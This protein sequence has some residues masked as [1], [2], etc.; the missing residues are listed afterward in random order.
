MTSGPHQVHIQ[1]TNSAEPDRSVSSRRTSGRDKTAGQPRGGTQRD[2][3]EGPLNPQVLGSSPRGVRTKAL[4]RTLTRAF[5]VLR[6]GVRN[7]I[8]HLRCLTP[9]VTPRLHLDTWG[10]ALSESLRNRF[11]AKVDRSGEHNAWTGSR[12][13][14]GAGKLKVDGKTVSARRVTWEFARGALA[15]GVVVKACPDD[16]A[17]VR[18]EYLSLRGEASVAN[19][20]R[21]PRATWIENRDPPERVKAHGHV[22]S[23]RRRAG[24]PAASHRAGQHRSPGDAGASDHETPAA[25]TASPDV[26]NNSQ[27]STSLGN[28]RSPGFTPSQ[29][30]GKPSLP[31]R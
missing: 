30:M 19:R 18:V 10:A 14:D 4:V 20:R 31:P 15:V 8:L 28:R 21:A 27:G 3:R 25:R 12:T 23:L 17:C 26:L 9:S 1:A 7:P 5:Q 16:Q 24:A 2:H 13:S 22:R 29:S 6:R 11:E